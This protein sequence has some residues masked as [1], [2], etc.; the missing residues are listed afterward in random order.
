MTISLEHIVRSGAHLELVAD[1]AGYLVL[2]VAEQCLQ[3]TPADESSIT[4][5][6]AGTITVHPRGSTRCAPDRLAAALGRLLSSAKGDNPGLVAIAAKPASELEQFVGDLR[7]ALV[8]LN[9]PAA[10]RAL[11]RLRRQIERLGPQVELGPRAEAVAPRPR[12]RVPVTAPSDPVD[13]TVDVDLEPA[14]E[15][16]A[17]FV[18]ATPRLGSLRV[19]PHVQTRKPVPRTRDDSGEPTRAL[20]LPTA[21]E[22]TEPLALTRRVAERRE[23]P[24]APVAHPPS[25]KPTTRTARRS[26]VREL[27]SGFRVEPAP[28]EAQLLAA[29]QV[30]VDSHGTPMP[31]VAQAAGR[32]SR[33]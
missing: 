21:P 27:V 31:P 24:R 32:T 3:G 25:P 19:E 26:D 16:T 4:L 1:T 13:F 11:V 22:E 23:A 33:R 9:R 18:A 6:E 15:Q 10:R 20:W 5:E 14:P 30:N 8:P 7:A 29:L 28:S 12:P 17:A 2:A